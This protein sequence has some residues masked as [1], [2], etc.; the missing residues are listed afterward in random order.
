MIIQ[1]LSKI[2]HQF[3]FLPD[4]ELHRASE[5]LNVPLH[6]LHE[7]VSFFPHFRRQAP[8][9]VLV[10]VCRDM[11]CHLHGASACRKRLETLAR[12]IGANR[13]EVKGVSCLGQCDGAPAVTINDQVYR[14]KSDEELGSLVRRAAS[15]EPLLPQTADRQPLSWKI[16]PYRGEARYDAVHRWCE[17][18]KGDTGGDLS[19]KRTRLG[20]PI[21]KTLETARLRGM[22]GACFPTSRKWSTVRRG[23][24]QP[25]VHR[26]QRR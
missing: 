26:L 9:S 14:G 2:Q 11:A 7:V 25:Q 15:G 18:W 13:I 16:N 21:L 23:L 3:G 4:E 12:E 6:R 8:L 19:R 10:R 24:R 22:G 20:D 5:R 17:G 1:E